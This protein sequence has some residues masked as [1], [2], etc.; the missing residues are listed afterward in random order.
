MKIVEN[1]VVLQYGEVGEA[2]M[3]SVKVHQSEAGKFVAI[4]PTSGGYPYAT[5][6]GSAENF[7]TVEKA[8]QYS[9]HFPGLKVRHVTITYEVSE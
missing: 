8:L 6:I 2:V 4:D 9:R 7:R 1:R 5:E 3:S